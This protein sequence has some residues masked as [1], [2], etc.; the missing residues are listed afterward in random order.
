KLLGGNGTKFVSDAYQF[1]SKKLDHATSALK[2]KLCNCKLDDQI[3]SLEKKLSKSEG[4]GYGDPTEKSI[5]RK[6]EKL[7]KEKKHLVPPQRTL[8]GKSQIG[9][10][11]GEAKSLCALCKRS[12]PPHHPAPALL[13]NKIKVA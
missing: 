3:K 7:E 6:K 8:Y 9:L 2:K 13:K 12:E 5:R 10:D 11:G 4:K 1:G